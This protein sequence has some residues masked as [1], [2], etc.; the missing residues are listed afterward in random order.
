MKTSGRMGS[1][2][3]RAPGMRRPA[4][5]LTTDWPTR[6]SSSHPGHTAPARG[7]PLAGRTVGSVMPRYGSNLTLRG[8]Q[9]LRTYRDFQHAIKP[10]AED[11]V[12]LAD[13]VERESMRDERGRV[14]SAGL[15][16]PHQAIHALLAAGAQR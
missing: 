16:D 15:H 10:V 1:S 5:S 8:V 6:I 12:G 3:S 2:S 7:A 4:V 11:A 13:L 14:E 9:T